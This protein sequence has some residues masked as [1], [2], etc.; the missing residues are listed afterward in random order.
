MVREYHLEPEISRL[1]EA[2]KREAAKFGQVSIVLAYADF[3]NNDLR[4]LQSDFQR[5]NVETRHVFSKTYE[6]GRR[7]NAADIEMSLD[8]QEMERSNQDIKTF[9]LVCGDR[10]FIPIVKRL[11]QRG[12]TVHIIGLK[13][14]TSRDLQNFVSSY[15]AIEELLGIIPTKKTITATA[16]RTGIT[17]PDII[18]SQLESAQKRLNFVSVKHFLNDIV[19]G[20][21]SEKNAIFNAAVDAGLIEL[22]S[23]PN[24]KNVE[25]QTKCCRLKKP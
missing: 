3:D 9:V 2:L 14:T 17:S 16:Q 23:I 13:V 25:Y 22:Y 7:K 8:A 5:T 24:P 4:G 10:D 6:D 12:K 1:I 20:E 19:K 15:T 11:Q 21:F 18:L